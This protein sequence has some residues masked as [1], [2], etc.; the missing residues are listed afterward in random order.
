M[1]DVYWLQQTE[2]DVPAEDD[3]LS[4]NEAIRLEGM[5]FVKRRNDWRLGRWTAKLA[6]AARLNM[7]SDRSSLASI[8]ILSAPSGAP[9]AVSCPITADVT[10]SLSHRAGAAICAV[11]PS[12]VELGCDLEVIEPRSDGFLED[13]FTAEERALVARSAG[14]DRPLLLALL[15]SAKES[16]L[17]AIRAG[18]RLD[19]RSVIVDLGS[20]EGAAKDMLDEW[21]PLQVRQDGGRV[22]QGWWQQD[23]SLL[24]TLVASPAPHPPLLLHVSAVRRGYEA[25]SVAQPLPPR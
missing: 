14:S 18:L 8:E 19:T 2:A 1:T 4:A 3:W 9:E 25:T 23:G 15:W 13:F 11:A 24:R 21:R 5:R 17:K 6:L 7:P 10:I 22:F 12:G 16:A 20:F